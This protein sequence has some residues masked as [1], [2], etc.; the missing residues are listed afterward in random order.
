MD[1]YL[2]CQNGQFIFSQPF[3][4]YGDSNDNDHENSESGAQQVNDNKEADIGQD[5]SQ[6]AI[7]EN[8]STADNGNA[9]ND[10]GNGD[11]LQRL[12]QRLPEDIR[13]IFECK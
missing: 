13:G 5:S 11:A 2:R 8:I 9:I 7:P 10:N 6:L 1:D 3:S 12:L 4:D